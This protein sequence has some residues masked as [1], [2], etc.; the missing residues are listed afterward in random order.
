[1]DQLET[2]PYD[3]L[4]QASDAALAQ[5]GKEFDAPLWDHSGYGLSWE[6]VIDGSFLPT[7]PVTDQGFAEAGRDVPPADRK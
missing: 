7:N 1:M 4:A 2:I 5:A 3:K 6:P